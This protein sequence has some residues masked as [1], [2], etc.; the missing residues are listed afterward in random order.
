[1][2]CLF[3]SGLSVFLCSAPFA[4]AVF[5]SSGTFVVPAGVDTI[6]VEAV[7]AGGNGGTNGG[8]GGGGGG[9]VLRTSAVTPGTTYS[10][11]VGAGG[12]ELAT[13][14]GGMGVL[15]NAGLNGTTVGNPNIGG[16]GAGGT[17]MG[18]DVNHTGGNGGGGYYTYFGGGGG[19][20][21]G[22][23][24]N[25]GPGG[26]T[27]AWNGSNCLT[28]GGS[29]G[30]GGGAPG[31]DGG[32]GAGF[33]DA[34]CTVSDPV[35]NGIAFGGGGGGG[36]GI[37]SPVG[38]GGGG[39]CI[40]T[41]N[42]ASSMDEPV[43]ESAPTLVCNPFTDRLALRN[44]RGDEHFELL[45]A[46]GRV[47]YSGAHIEQQDLSQLKAGA[48]LLRVITGGGVRTLKAIKEIER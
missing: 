33:T 11:V 31:G 48:H 14:V 28:P 19:G 17:A 27:I 34:N 38:V 37:G 8:G 26:N 23:T 7:G 12:S 13:I 22:A 21:A 32:K 10:I 41:W 25:G 29:A 42:G 44:L 30:I 45:D 4:Q 35:G 46:T 6:T 47:I 2:K 20:A 39:I 1:M 18:G 36:N 40:I 5:T 24:G 16:G 43:I 9:Y 15:A 3:A